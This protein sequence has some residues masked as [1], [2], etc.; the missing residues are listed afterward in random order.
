MSS[1]ISKSL[2]IMYL[3]KKKHV[4]F[5]ML[6]S[7]GCVF[8]RFIPFTFS[9]ISEVSN[10]QWSWFP[11]HQTSQMP[12]EAVLHVVF[13]RV[14]QK[15]TKN[16]EPWTRITGKMLLSFATSTNKKSLSLYIINIWERLYVYVNIRYIILMVE[17]TWISSARIYKKTLI[18]PQST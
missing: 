8:S 1:G 3:L 4:I 14:T 13:F 12:I 15:M 16:D 17:L 2:K 10:R 6:V 9:A 11:R 7:R 5:V 18:K